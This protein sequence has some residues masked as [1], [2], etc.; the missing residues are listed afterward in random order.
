MTYFFGEINISN[1]DKVKFILTWLPL[2]KELGFNQECPVILGNGWGDAKR[3]SDFY[4]DLYDFLSQA[5]RM[6]FAEFL[7]VNGEV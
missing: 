2:A 3:Y 4:H 1:K 5:H 6:D 7:K